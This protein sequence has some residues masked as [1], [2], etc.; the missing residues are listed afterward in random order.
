MSK[1]TKMQRFIPS[2]YRPTENPYVQGLLAAWSGEDDNI[3]TSISDAKEQL[4]VKYAKLQFLDALGSNVG[5][6]RPTT[7]NLADEQYRQLIPA[8]SFRPKQMRLTILKVLEVFFGENN[9]NIFIAELN[10]NEIVIQIPSSVP[11]LR[12]SLR[13]SNH[14]KC[15]S[16]E[17]TAVDNIAKTMIINLDNSTKSVVE[18]ELQDAVIGQGYQ[19]LTVVSNTA[20]TTGITLQFNAAA[21]ISGYTLGRFVA[22]NV[23]NYPSAYV[24]DPTRGFTVT[25]QRGILGQNIVAGNIY[26]TL[27]M[28][29]A[30]NIPDTT[31]K[32]VFNFGRTG[33][34]AGIT[35]F[36]RPNNTTLLLDPSYNFTTNHS[37]GEMVNVIVQPYQTPAIT[38]IDYPVYIVGVTAARIL[39]QQIVESVT[40]SGVVVRWLI[41]EPECI[42]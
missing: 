38:G 8:L 3:V 36:G 4:F 12:R 32:I 17:I 5:V 16:G 25:K 35:Y 24:P 41:K 29:D 26:P 10:P 18:D 19:A 1:L 23:T 22:A 20:G 27:S 21:D 30:S 9:P 2:L 11:A 15:Y 42:C 37:I 14:F 39:A 40:A 6:F 34:E 7:I 28:Q 31:G 33:E 13:G